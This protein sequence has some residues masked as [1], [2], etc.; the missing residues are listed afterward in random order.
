MRVLKIFPERNIMSTMDLIFIV[1][2]SVFSIVGAIICVYWYIFWQ[3]NYEGELITHGPYKFVRHPFYSGFLIL[4]IGLNLIYPSFEPRL[5]LIFTLA[6]LGSFIPK[7][8]A[9]LITQYKK[10]YEDYME[11]VSYKLIPFIW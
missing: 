9:R 3:R 6:V 1:V 8:E 5:L 2:G 4:T 10:K 7:E 11:K